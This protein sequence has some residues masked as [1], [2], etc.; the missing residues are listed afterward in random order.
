[1]FLKFPEVF[2]VMKYI[3]IVICL[4]CMHFK[5]YSQSL[6]MQ[7]I[8]NEDSVSNNF[9]K[10]TDSK[11]KLDIAGSRIRFDLGFSHYTGDIFRSSQVLNLWKYMADMNTRFSGLGGCLGT[12]NLTASML[13]LHQSELEDAWTFLIRKWC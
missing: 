3:L 11:G 9:I 1:M 5:V 12:M 2:I 13:D 10:N 6:N 4:V 8:S 7:A